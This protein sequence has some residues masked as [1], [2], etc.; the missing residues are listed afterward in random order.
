M[1]KI[2][3]GSLMIVLIFSLAACGNGSNEATE[4]RTVSMFGGTDPNATVYQDI[5]DRFETDYGVSINDT[6][7][8]SNEIWKTSVVSSFYSGTEPDV[9]FFFTGATAAPFVENDMVVSI[10]EI[11]EEYPDYASNISE[12]VMDPYAVPIKGFVEGI[13]V[14]TELFT[15]NLETY[16]DKDVWTWQD[17]HDIADELISR[18]IIPF[19]FGAED[20]P[21]YW[22][23]HLVL[24]FNGPEAFF[25][26]PEPG[27]FSG[28]TATAEG[29]KWVEALSMLDQLADEGWFGDTRGNQKN[30]IANQLFKTGQAAMILDGSWFAGG[31]EGTS[32]DPDKTMMVPFPAIPE[33]EGGMNQ[34][35]M[36]SGFTSG[37]YITR[38]AWEDEAKRELAVDFITEMT[39]TESIVAYAELGGIPSDPSAVVDNLNGISVSM[40]G[41]PARTDTATLPLSDASAAGSFTE[42]VKKSAA[43]LEGSRDEI[44]EALE[45]FANLN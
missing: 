2:I 9:L 37:F 28:A 25:N 8:T 13:F 39:K 33:S 7:A 44:I 34:Y 26:I 15:G 5:I 24:G 31:I 18:D 16:L 14:N 22:I 12:N 42:L 23:E 6:S 45:S 20:V 43:Y 38:Q 10:E 40:N 27:S 19:A 21:H 4:L 30:E 29:E 32:V 1:K 3:L 41:M 35:Y 36:Q 17:F 11:R